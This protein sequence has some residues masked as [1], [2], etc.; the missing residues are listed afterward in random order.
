MA[1]LGD[2]YCAV[3]VA[4]GFSN[5]MTLLAESRKP[6]VGHN[7]LFDIVYMLCQLVATKRTWADFKNKLQSFFPAGLYDTKH[8]AK[9]LLKRHEGLFPDTSLGPLYERLKSEEAA[10]AH[11]ALLS[12]SPQCAPS[13]PLNF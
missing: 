12:A 2:A 4:G 10:L 5:V 3:Q 7:C 13:R 11:R 1:V 6:L 8:L 9:V